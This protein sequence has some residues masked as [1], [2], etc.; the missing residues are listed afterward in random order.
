MRNFPV[1]SGMNLTLQEIDDQYADALEALNAYYNPFNAFSNVRFLGY[2]ST[3]LLAELTIRRTENETLATLSLLAAL[4]AALRIDYFSRCAE[5]RKD[6][7]S[8]KFRAIYRKRDIR[9]R[10]DEDILDTWRFS[11][12]GNNSLISEI[13]SAFRLRHWLAHGRYW[14]PKLGR[15]YDYLGI[16]LIC[17]SA[18]EAFSLRL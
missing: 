14:S 13:K 1:L 2:T 12:I 7:V 18:N 15:Q 9:A 16:N 3:E 6:D 8:R 4:E 5:R 17:Q 11:T 10:L